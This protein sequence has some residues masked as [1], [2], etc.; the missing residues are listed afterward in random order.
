[1]LFEK[2]KVLDW[3]N[4]DP[5]NSP[6]AYYSREFSDFRNFL[7][8]RLRNDLIRFVRRLD[9]SDN[10]FFQIRQKR[11]ANLLNKIVKIAKS[12]AAGNDE[13]L[14]NRTQSK[15]DPTKEYFLYE[16]VKDIVAVRY[17]CL[18]YGAL[19]TLL[20]LILRSESLRISDYEVYRPFFSEYDRP[21]DDI[22]LDLF[23]SVATERPNVLYKTSNYELIHSE[24]RFGAPVD[25]QSV[26]KLSG[27]LISSR[28]YS[29]PD[30]DGGDLLSK[31]L[32]DFRMQI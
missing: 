22:S 29:I 1:M 11:P 20:K 25:L 4:Y 23:E 14:S 12:L 28:G 31:K 24:V 10:V 18:D 30:E 16:F 13:F 27:D 26:K 5:A 7:E 2:R 17:I 8:H 9:L 6:N 19:E 3:I 32:F 15:I 21:G